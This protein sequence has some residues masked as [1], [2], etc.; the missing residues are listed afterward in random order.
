MANILGVQNIRANLT[1]VFGV[2]YPIAAAAATTAA[3]AT[4][5][6]ITNDNQNINYADNAMCESYM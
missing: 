2:L 3:T 5:Y 1:S 6:S 4:I